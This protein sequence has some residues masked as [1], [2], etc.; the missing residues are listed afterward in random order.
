MRKKI[1]WRVV[2]GWMVATMLLASCAPAAI[3]E[4]AAVK[5]GVAL[6]V[7]EPNYGGILTMAR[8]NDVHSGFAY[9]DTGDLVSSRSYGDWWHLK[10]IILEGLI[11]YQPAKGPRGTG[12][13]GTE[14]VPDANPLL[15][16]GWLAEGWEFDMENETIKITM[17]KGIHWQDGTE[18]TAEDV[19]YTF[20]LLYGG[21]HVKSPWVVRRPYI[22]NVENPQESIYLDPDDPTGRTV[23]FEARPGFMGELWV[24]LFA[25]WDT[26]Y[27]R[28]LGDRN[29][30]GTWEDVFGTGPYVI[31]DYVPGSL[32]TYGRAPNPYW[33]SDPFNPDNLLP[34]PDGFR[35][36][37]IP[38][39]STRLAGLR[40]GKIDILDT[41][42]LEDAQSLWQTNPELQWRER[43][44]SSGPTLWLRHDVAPFDDVRVRRALMMAIDHDELVADFYE[45]QADK[46]YFPT[47]PGQPLDIHVP[48]EDMPQDV[49]ELY[50]YHPDKAKSLLAD[51]GY[52][53]GFE[54]G[55][56]VSNVNDAGIDILN[57][58]K[59]YYEKVNVNLEINVL[60]HGA[61]VQ[62]GRA[63]SYPHGYMTTVSA[64]SAYNWFHTLPERLQNWGKVDNPV[65]NQYA[66]VQLE[67]FLRDPEGWVKLW[68]EATEE[69]QRLA[70]FIQTPMPKQYNFWQPWVKSYFGE[71]THHP[72][73]TLLQDLAVRGLW[74]DQELKASK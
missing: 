4:G 60:E 43:P 6:E 74:I 31:T 7:E 35:W 41:I 15:N 70:F 27:P 9:T 1:I 32:I 11:S 5:E 10:G 14:P 26:L 29:G 68:P 23:V 71:M 8:A 49:K 20:H 18:V 38:D 13:W 55:V 66:K 62:R 19:L 22:R 51:A 44:T 33:Q 64:W 36:L 37:I 3:E 53:D 56:D 65:A 25:Y 2:G 63:R 16:Q 12:E 61:F 39:L 59:F 46:F 72:G 54:L 42:N 57:V 34:Y 21:L 24:L 47:F 40:T 28:S 52:P 48:I 69:I 45:G 73:P 50:E 17:R 67:N 30:F 58:L